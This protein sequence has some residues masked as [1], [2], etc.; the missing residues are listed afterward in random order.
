VFYRR[1]ASSEC[2]KHEVVST[3]GLVDLKCYPGVT[4]DFSYKL[5]WPDYHV[6]RGN[7]KCEGEPDLTVDITDDNF[8]WFNTDDGI[9]DSV[10]QRSFQQWQKSGAS[11]GMWF[12]MGV[13]AS[14]MMVVLQ[15]WKD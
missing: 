13:L 11:Q 14:L 1:Y 6:Y 15:L 8:C 4:G 12:N 9:D 3:N 10:N 7:I 5:V 2:V